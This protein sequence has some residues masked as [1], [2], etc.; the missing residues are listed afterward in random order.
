MNFSTLINIFLIV[1]INPLPIQA[2]EEESSWFS[3]W[4]DKAS[5]ALE[6]YVD[7]ADIE[8]AK[9]MADEIS[10]ASNQVIDQ[11]MQQFLDQEIEQTE[12]Q[13]DV[14]EE[15][16]VDI[17]E[18]DIPDGKKGRTIEAD[19]NNKKIFR[20]TLEQEYILGKTQKLEIKFASKSKTSKKNIIK[21]IQKFFCNTFI[22][23]N[24][25]IYDTA[26]GI[27]I[28]T[29]LDPCIY[30]ARAYQGKY[31]IAQLNDSEKEALQILKRELPL[32]IKGKNNDYDKA[33]AIHDWIIKNVYYKKADN[34]QHGDQALVKG[35]VVCAGYA[36]VY[37][38][39][40][41]AIG[42]PCVVVVENVHAWN[43]A[44][45]DGTWTHIDVTWGD[46]GDKPV[47]TYFGL[48]HTDMNKVHNRLCKLYPYLPDCKDET[49]SY[50]YRNFTHVGSNSALTKAIE[51]GKPNEDMQMC[52]YF[53][54]SM[55]KK[56]FANIA[57]KCTNEHANVSGW[58]YEPS[59]KRTAILYFKE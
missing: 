59:M 48:N 22:M 58:S 16:A 6:E 9:Q 24:T 38:T 53:D 40:M 27:V 10:T 11:L 32:I 15:P 30:L 50:A 51:K 37:S 21:H 56:S 28:D 42:I 36:R 31:P 4:G 52:F 26:E 12:G 3:G 8:K 35:Y 14:T 25:R 19:L 13:S 43:M 47:Y 29:N 18:D 23:R 55:S 34:H 46:A 49:M 17:I 41:E 1:A 39:M 44:L 20:Q 33:V 5:K 45:I 2:Q 54:K 57:S 7:P